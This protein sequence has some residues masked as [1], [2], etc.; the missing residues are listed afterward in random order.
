MG[1]G[2]HL[3][4]RHDRTKNDPSVTR[5]SSFPCFSPFASH[6]PTAAYIAPGPLGAVGH[7]WAIVAMGPPLRYVCPP[8]EPAAHEEA[9]RI[10]VV[11]DEKVIREILADFLTLEGY[12]VRTVEDG[13][14][15]MREL[16]RRSYNLVISDLKMPSLGGL[17][18]LAEIAEAKINVLTIIMTG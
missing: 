4:R 10:L 2:A 1:V 7:R 14:S 5:I 17:E 15:A 9:P 16:Q 18:L 8:M 6:L 11:D 12:V 3:L 13:Q